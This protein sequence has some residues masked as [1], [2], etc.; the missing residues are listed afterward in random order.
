MRLEPDSR[1]KEEIIQLIDRE[2]QRREKSIRNRN[3]IDVLFRLFPGVHALKEVLTGSKDALDFERQKLT[4]ERI[5]DLLVGIDKKLSGE[6]ISSMD[7]GLKILIER[8]VSDGDII[9]L[10]G[11]TSNESVRK[12]FEK[13]LSVTIKDVSARGN[14]TGVKLGV[15]KEMPVKE[16]VKIETGAGKVEIDPKFGKVIFGKGFRKQ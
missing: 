1:M 8:V 5:L 2:L 14:I 10:D 11:K 6:A 9:G 4:I 15:D 13:P 12:V 16:H 3:A 7:E